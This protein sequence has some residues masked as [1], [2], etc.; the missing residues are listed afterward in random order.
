MKE[1]T[2][3]IGVSYDAGKA[4]YRA[5][6]LYGSFKCIKFFALSDSS[7]RTLNYIEQVL[8]KP[9]NCTIKMKPRLRL[10]YTAM[11]CSFVPFL[12]KQ[13]AINYYDQNFQLKY[14]PCAALGSL[15]GFALCN[16]ILYNKEIVPL[17]GASSIGVVYG[18]MYCYLIRKMTM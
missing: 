18:L 8:W 12:S 15:N 5:I 13:L 6:L 2:F 7:S 3:D 17:V 11:L 4:F 1:L 9:S 16:L 10:F 14:G